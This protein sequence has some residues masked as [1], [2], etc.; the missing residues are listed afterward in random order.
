MKERISSQGHGIHLSKHGMAEI[1][2]GLRLHYVTAGME[3]EL[4]FSCVGS[5]GPGVGGVMLCQ[6]W[7]CSG[8][9]TRTG[10]TNTS[11][12]DIPLAL[13]KLAYAK[14]PCIICSF[15]WQRE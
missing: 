2:P 10:P 14:P 11:V 8:T 12:I 7:G 13:L 1:N 6:P 15:D 9:M 4:S 5:H 3:I